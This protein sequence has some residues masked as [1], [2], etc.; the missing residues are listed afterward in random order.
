MT[1][2]ARRIAELSPE[3]RLLLEQL[4][5]ARAS[6]PAGATPAPAAAPSPI[7]APE[8]PDL[9]PA[10]GAVSDIDQLPL[11][12]D[13]SPAA[14][15]ANYRCFYDAVSA[16]LDASD[17]GPFSLFL[18]YG[19][20]PT[21]SPQYAAVELPAHHL[22]KNSVKLVL[23]VIGDC[24]LGDR[25][26]LDVGCGR[27]GT[28][29]VLRQ[30]FAAQTITGLDLSSRAIAF[31]RAT[32]RAPEVRFEEGDA[33]HLPFGDASFDVVTNIESS[34]SYPNINTFYAEVFRVLT[35][36]GYFLYTD[37]LP[38]EFMNGAVVFLR[39]LG[40]S[41]EREQDITANVLLS[42]DEIAHTRVQAYDRQNDTQLM[43]DFLGVPGSQIYEEMRQRRWTY[44]I[45][46]FK[47]SVAPSMA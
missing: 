26:V 16:Q 30:F 37:V 42:C 33:E 4:L 12:G 31:C 36:G 43:G 47:K 25:R 14:V 11:P 34:H 45:F 6:A 38:V 32:H 13:A 18:N 9:M 35:P 2:L 28:V 1:E 24:E 10:A 27:G 40:F 3:K 5:K 39:A 21:Q 29:A 41:V 17:F 44:K 15:K 46:K 23:E 8:R 22:N 20:V 19:Y 7:D